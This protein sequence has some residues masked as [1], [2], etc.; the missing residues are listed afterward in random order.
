MTTNSKVY[1][2]SKHNYSNF[3]NSA[4]RTGTKVAYLQTDMVKYLLWEL[5]ICSIRSE[6][7]LTGMF[8]DLKE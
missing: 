6:N 5:L 2:L 3:K 1:V 8:I 4:M 7:T